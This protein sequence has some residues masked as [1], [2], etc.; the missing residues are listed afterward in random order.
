VGSFLVEWA[1]H[2]FGKAMVGEYGRKV[3]QAFDELI[4]HENDKVK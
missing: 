4:A 3:G 1:T 2:P